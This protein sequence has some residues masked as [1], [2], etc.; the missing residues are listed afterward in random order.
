MMKEKGAE[1]AERFSLLE[2]ELV[3]LGA[4]EEAEGRQ[5][6]CDV[7]RRLL[8]QLADERHRNAQLNAQLA[9]QRQSLSHLESQLAA[10]TIARA[11]LHQSTSN[12]SHALTHALHDAIQQLKQC[13]TQMTQ[14]LQ[15]ISLLESELRRLRAADESRREETE[16]ETEAVREG[17]MRRESVREESAGGESDE[18]SRGTPLPPPDYGLLGHSRECP[19]CSRSF[20]VEDSVGQAEF[21]AHVDECA[22]RGASEP[23]SG[24]EESQQVVCPICSLTLPSGPHVREL[25]KQHMDGHFNTP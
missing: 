6:L 22:E 25:L 1:E 7:N 12:T 16:R 3:M 18:S 21:E 2:D 24:S 5:S 10:P 9:E 15:H 4:S 8:A 17:A 11:S 19:V 14:D 13:K 20:E 23:S